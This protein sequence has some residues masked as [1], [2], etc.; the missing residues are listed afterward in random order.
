MRDSERC[1]LFV[2]REPFGGAD[3]PLG[4]GVGSRLAAVGQS[5]ERRAMRSRQHARVQRD[6]L[7]SSV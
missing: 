4:S 2:R 3:S 1:R 6:V 5:G 7:G